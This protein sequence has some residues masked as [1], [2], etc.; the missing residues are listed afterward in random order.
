MNIVDLLLVLVIV[1]SAWSGWHRGFLLTTIGLVCWAGSLVMSFW[2]YPYTAL[3]MGRH[4][5]SL[6]VWI[7][8]LSFLITFILIQLLL[9]LIFSAFL[10]ATPLSVHTSFINKFLGIIPGIISGLITALV[11]A[12]LLMALPL[13]PRITKY[14][15]NSAVADNLAVKAEWLE[16]RLSPIFDKAISRTVT[17]L[18]IEPNSEK[19]VKL[20][21]TTT[22]ISV[23]PALEDQMLQ[24]VN[25]ERAKAGLRPLVKDAELQAVARSHS[26]DMFARGYFSHITP[27]GKSPFDR[28]KDAHIDF[29][30]AGENLALAPTLDIA[31]T[32]LMN[33]PGHRANILNPGFGRVGIGI[34]DGG[35]HG[36]MISQEFRN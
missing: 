10:R 6:G 35:M 21:Y 22:D 8:P 36:L 30:Q 33:S 17:K 32:G 26:E 28:M 11:I 1:M 34:I 20:P 29:L 19:A 14:T 2:L 12:V 25:E 5:P 3:A 24:L 27:E 7:L 9:S 31:H 18:T 16:S 23:R 13:A 15:A 4:A